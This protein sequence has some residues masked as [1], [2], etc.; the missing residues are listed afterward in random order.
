MRG[1]Q[2]H[3][4]SGDNPLPTNMTLYADC[5]CGAAVP[6]AEPGQIAFFVDTTLPAASRATPLFDSVEAAVRF[7]ER[8]RAEVGVALLALA[9]RP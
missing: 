1:T 6:F 7:G 9:S 8:R 2:P 4:I 3:F 5:A